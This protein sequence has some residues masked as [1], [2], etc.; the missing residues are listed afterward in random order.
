MLLGG[1]AGAAVYILNQ[2]GLMKALKDRVIKITKDRL[3]T[4]Y[5]GLLC[6]TRPAEQEADMTKVDMPFVVRKDRVPPPSA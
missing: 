1:A 3:E 4:R 2:L 6:E 5:F